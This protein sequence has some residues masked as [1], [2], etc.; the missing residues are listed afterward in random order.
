ME[1]QGTVTLLEKVTLQGKCWL[2]NRVY[3]NR[4]YVVDLLTF[5]LLIG[6]LL[7]E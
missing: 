7:N 6:V 2:Y 3:L 4:G 1:E 5:Y